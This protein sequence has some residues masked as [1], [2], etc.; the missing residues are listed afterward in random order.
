[1]YVALL[2][3]GVI[4][5]VLSYNYY[6]VDTQN[7]IRTESNIEFVHFLTQGAFP[8]QNALKFLLAFPL[9]LFLLS[10]FDAL[11]E[12]LRGSALS[13]VERCGRIVTLV[14]PGLFCVSYCFSGFTW[15]TNSQII[16]QVL[17][18][19]GTTI[20]G[21]IM[22]DLLLLFLLTA[23]LLLGSENIPLERATMMKTT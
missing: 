11:G 22:I 5:L 23:S 18:S 10:W 3:C 4:D 16:Y 2:G 8:I 1:M 14:I 12:N 19:I 9:L 20:Q 17:T 6:V 7:F 21:L 13:F 15:Y